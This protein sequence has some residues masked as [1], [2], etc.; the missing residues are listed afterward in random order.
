MV[1]YQ[2]GL[3]NWRILREDMSVELSHD[4]TFD[5][6]LYPGISPHDPAGLIAP[7]EPFLE[8]FSNDEEICSFPCPIQLAD[9]ESKD[10]DGEVERYLQQPSN[11]TDQLS[12][13]PIRASSP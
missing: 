1:G 3:H 5:K 4:V 2:L 6:N 12:E 8:D 10:S 9:H 11:S 7:L 13:Q